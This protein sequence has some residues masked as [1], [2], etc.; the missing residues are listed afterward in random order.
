MTD[1]FVR[2][3]H[4]V[5][6]KD[7]TVDQVMKII[8][9]AQ[10]FKRGTADFYLRQP[11]YAVNMF[12]ENSTRT[13]SSFEMAER[14]L[15]IQTIPFFPQAS[16][17]KKGETL[18]DTLLTLGA[19]G[20]NLAVIRHSENEYYNQLI[21]LRPD[22]HLNVGILNAGDGSG[23]H[24]SQC[25]L[26]M[27]TIYEQFGHFAGLKVAIIGDLTNS[28]VARSDMQ[29]LKTLGAT[30]YFAGPENWF[31]DEFKA[32]GEY[33]D[34][35]DLVDMVDVVMLL[36]VQHER[37]AAGEDDQFDAAAY[38][39]Q[40]GINQER[41]DRMKDQT[42][43]MHPGPIN[44]DVEFANALVE[45]PKSRFVNQMQ[46]GVFARMAMLEAVLRGRQLGGLE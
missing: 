32:Y 20:C 7:L 16:S 23:Q 21:N 46:N 4:F 26:D 13:R 19:V 40:Y 15:G 41:Y 31:S 9:R 12:F 43:I 17:M 33:R 27:L 36:R 45:A 18:Y 2:L 30:L 25:M 8:H 6:V 44:R 14:R 37:H 22:Q 29:M 1:E 5:S 38:H 28:R 24:P 39:K 10:A 35:D 34:V 3:P 11:V 42:I